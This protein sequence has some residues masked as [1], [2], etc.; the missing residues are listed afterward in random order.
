MAEKK[1]ITDIEK[2]RPVKMH[3]CRP[4]WVDHINRRLE[5]ERRTRRLKEDFS[6]VA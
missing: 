1:V 3:E 6:S 5:E 2:A 4:V